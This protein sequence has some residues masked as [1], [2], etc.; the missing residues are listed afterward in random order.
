MGRVRCAVVRMDLPHQPTVWNDSALG[1]PDFVIP[2]IVNQINERELRR[3]LK[4]SVKRYLTKA[5]EIKTDN[6]GAQANLGN[7][8][9]QKGQLDEAI[10]HYYTALEIKPIYAEVHSNLG[11]ALL[12]KSRT[13]DPAV[14]R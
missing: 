4:N 10:A 14:K 6:V 9:L 1:K 5:L 8:L 7:A 12:H 11:N 13:A 3:R 2:W